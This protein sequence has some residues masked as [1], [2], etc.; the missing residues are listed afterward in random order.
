MNE[1]KQYR[2]VEVFYSI[3]GEGRHAG[4]AA[5]FIRFAGCN[6]KCEWCDTASGIYNEELDKEFLLAKTQGQLTDYPHSRR[7]NREILILTGGEPLLQV[8][9]YLVN[10][11]KGRYGYIAI[12]TNGTIPLSSSFDWVTVSPKNLD[13][14][15]ACTNKHWFNG[16]PNEVKI[17]VPTPGWAQQ[18]LDI[19]ADVATKAG[20]THLYLQPLDCESIR[21]S[22]QWVVDHVKRD[23]RWRVS[24]QTQKVLG[25]R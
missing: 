18:D 6:L 3:Q 16:L 10:I 22:Y 17:V 19:A 23:P 5:V 8:D 21:D 2:I 14:F 1:E 7:E 11:L 25:I 4:R 24:I 20:I 15:L 13:T 12:E 9:D